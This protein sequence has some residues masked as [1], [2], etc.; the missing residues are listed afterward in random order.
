MKSQ[1]FTYWLQGFFELSEADTLSKAQVGMIKQHLALVFDKKTDPLL[2]NPDEKLEGDELQ[3]VLREL[4]PDHTLPNPWT[5]PQYI[6]PDR[7]LDWDRT[8]IT[9]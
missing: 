9:C 1:D 3:K 2:V 7:P 6:S 8:K 4:Y 5:L